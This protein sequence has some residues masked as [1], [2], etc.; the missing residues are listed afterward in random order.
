MERE[1]LEVHNAREALAQ[2]EREVRE[3][4]DRVGSIIG[5]DDVLDINA[6]GTVHSVARSTL[7]QAPGSALAALFS[8]RWD[9]GMQRDT[10]GRPFLDVDP[11]CFEHI[12]CFLRLKRIEGPEEPAPVPQ[13]EAHKREAF[14]MFLRYYGL[15]EYV[16]PSSSKKVAVFSPPPAPPREHQ[17][18]ATEIRGYLV[19]FD[20]RFRLHAVYL[21]LL[22]TVEGCQ[23]LVGR[24]PH[25]IKELPLRSRALSQDAHLTHVAE[26]FDLLLEPPECCIMVRGNGSAQVKYQA[27]HFSDRLVGRFVINSKCMLPPDNSDPRRLP[28]LPPDNNSYQL[29]MAI[30]TFDA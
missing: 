19:R 17:L 28:P 7:C 24:G 23:V 12:L 16:Y 5:E 11:C 6:G 29:H 22:G 10:A 1:A 25:L 21:G 18:P 13:V 9:E 15:F 4:E 2:R 20:V 14:N 8:G 27:V 30:E 26:G 3:L